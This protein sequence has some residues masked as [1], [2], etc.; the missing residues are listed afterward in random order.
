M[1]FLL[2][3]PVLALTGIGVPAVFSTITLTVVATVPV[4]ILTLL[5][6]A[7]PA[8]LLLLSLLP[9]DLFFLNLDILLVR[10]VVALLP[11]APLSRLRIHLTRH[12]SWYILW[13][14]TPLWRRAPR[15][16]REG[17]KHRDIFSVFCGVS[18]TKV[19]A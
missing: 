6:L 16:R 4:G 7:P 5:L 8:I 15:R 18:S 12:C 2:F 17:T 11:L 10:F 14:A 1:P 9:M 3:F 13:L 19:L